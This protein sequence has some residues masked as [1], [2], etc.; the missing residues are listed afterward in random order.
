MKDAAGYDEGFS[1]V[2]DFRAHPV[3]DADAGSLG[4]PV[5]GR[6][7]RRDSGEILS[8]ELSRRFRAAT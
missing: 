7:R 4:V 2:R 5:D 1:I 3:D 8:D 6:Q